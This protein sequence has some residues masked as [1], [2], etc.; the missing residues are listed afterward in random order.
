MCF[1]SK[2]AGGGGGDDEPAPRPAQQ[3]QQSEKKQQ[4]Q[5][6]QPRP[7]SGGGSDVK[8][9]QSHGGG[10]PGDGGYA[11]GGG[12]SGLQRADEY[13]PPA[14]PPPGQQT[15][16]APP[17]GPPPGQQMQY[18]PPS[19]P[20]P[21]HQAD[22]YAPP[23]GPTPTHSTEYAPPAGP[24]PG[25]QGD[26]A[27]PAGPPPGKQQDD[28]APPPGPPP[29]SNDW[30]A[31]P[32]DA[33]PDQAHSK[34]EHDWQAAVPDTSLF[35]D[36]PPFFS[37]YDRS[38][39]TNASE[40][41][42]IA[43]EQWCEQYPLARPLVLDEAGQAALQDYNFR[44]IEPVGFNGSLNWLGKGHWAA[45]TAKGSPDR[46]IISYPPL[47]VVNQH[48]PTRT[49]QAKT[50]YYEVKLLGSSRETSVA[51]GFAA[52]PYPSFRMPGWHRG[53]LAVHGDDGHKFINDRWGGKDFTGEFRRGDT[54]GLGVTLRPPPGGGAHPKVDIFFTRNGARVG[55]WDLH[56]ETD[57]EQ[58]LPV[59][60]LEGFHD[61]S[62]AVGT[63]DAVSF[64][65][66][67]DPAKW[68]YRDVQ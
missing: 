61:L 22:S 46:C 5:Q 45:S 12:P 10:G 60:G 50:I 17:S 11:S 48:D 25:R 21:G 44:L 64:E 6:Q 68:M 14:G 2:D 39:T 16:Y 56:E 35:P 41:E 29:A 33:P 32:K 65:V 13:A 52:L 37:G 43:G 54:Y 31:P 59:T 3:Q 36:P 67:L 58:D 53:S 40:E 7:F 24:P 51:M 30:A 49:Q 63:F 66:V 34:L 4:Q 15:Q 28:Y 19:G 20:P 62:C 18:A 8:G 55:G 47:Y 38:H 42:A 23:P 27:P 57:A 1:G 26:Y 9:K